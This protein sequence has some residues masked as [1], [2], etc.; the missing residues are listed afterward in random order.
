[1]NPK[2]GVANGAC[3]SWDVVVGG[4]GER[5]KE[6]EE[7]NKAAKVVGVSSV[8]NHACGEFAEIGRKQ[9]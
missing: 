9:L 4:D 6:S 1:M 3:G 8:V 5:E 2:V 7:K